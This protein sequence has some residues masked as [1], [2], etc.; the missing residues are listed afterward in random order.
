MSAL[1]PPGNPQL[2]A[3]RARVA[4]GGIGGGASGPTGATGPAG[5][6]GGATGATGSS[7]VTGATGATGASLPGATG[8]TGAVGATGA[9][10]TGSV[11]ATGATGAGGSGATGA[12][13]SGATGATGPAGSATPGVILVPPPTGVAVT[14]TAN[15]VAAETARIAANGKM[16]FPP[17]MATPYAVNGPIAAVASR[18]EGNGTTLQAANNQPIV[19]TSGVAGIFS[20][21]TFDANR[22]GGRTGIAALLRSSDTQWRFVNC[23]FNNCVRNGVRSANST[24]ATLGAVVQV[25]PG[26]ALTVSVIDPHFIQASG[27]TITLTV[28][29]GGA[30]GTATVQQA[31]GLGTQIIFPQFQLGFPNGAT[32]F[33]IEAGILVTAAADGFVPG[34]TYTFPI[35][36]GNDSINIEAQ[37]ENCTAAQCGTTYATAGLIGNY[38]NPT[39]NST[40]AAGTVSTVLGNPLITGVGTA[41]LSLGLRAGDGFYVNGCTTIIDGLTVPKR[42]VILVVLNDTQIVVDAGWAPEQTLVGR[43][44]AATSGAAVYEDTS[45]GE[46][47]FTRL[48]GFFAESC[49]TSFIFGGNSGPHLDMCSAHLYAINGFVIGSG[50]FAD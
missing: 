23:N 10:A 39:Y 1:G 30:R 47:N 46:V 14:D 31:G 21:F 45:T 11:G 36:T 37:F 19:A 12:T 9:G 34:T 5:S 7:G 44:Y 8:A 3:L 49:V 25:G 13:G 2:D 41:F 38:P 20:G 33:A 18:W 15:I 28:T 24:N 16:I 48:T 17:T 42:F 26:P 32:S 43:D 29:L 22:A 4:V 50:A 35:L 40:A 6:P 27:S